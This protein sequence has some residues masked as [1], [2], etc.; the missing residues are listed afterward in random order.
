MRARFKSSWRV[1]PAPLLVAPERS[2]FMRNQDDLPRPA[3][4]DE[5]VV[6][7]PES[8]GHATCVC[9]SGL[10]ESGGSVGSRHASRETGG[11]AFQMRRPPSWRKLRSPDGS[12]SS[13]RLE[14]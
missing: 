12:Q 11:K 2:Y 8:F 1:Y 4:D 7:A 10:H 14:E 3:P 6:K 13:K 5:L 9:V